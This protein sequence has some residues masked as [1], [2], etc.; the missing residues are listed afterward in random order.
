MEIQET[1]L[2]LIA[3]HTGNPEV[4]LADELNNDLGMDSL[5][6]VEFIMTLEEEFNIEIYDEQVDS[7]VTVQ[8]VVDIVE[9]KKQ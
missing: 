2:K 5:D 8:N 9:S 6:A 7:L 1:V 4:T 3:K